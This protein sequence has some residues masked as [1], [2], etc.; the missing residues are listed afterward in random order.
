M[1][2]QPLF[3]FPVNSKV[4]IVGVPSMRG[5]T[6]D[7]INDSGIH[8]HNSEIGHTVIS[9]MSDAIYHDAV[10]NKEVEYNSSDNIIEQPIKKERAK[11]GSL[12][13]KMADINIPS[14]KFTIKELAEHNDIPYP[15]AMKWAEENCFIS[16][17]KEKPAG[18]RGRTAKYYSVSK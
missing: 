16:G 8:V 9:A 7:R 15:Y 4:D 18:Q 12:I 14:D 6:I 11:R 13:E 1:N 17:K 3:S 2:P 5:L 10:N